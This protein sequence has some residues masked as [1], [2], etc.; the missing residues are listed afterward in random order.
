[1]NT[2]KPF[3]LAVEEYRLPMHYEKEKNHLM[4]SYLKT[5]IV[6]KTARQKQK[7]QMPQKQNTI[8]DVEPTLITFVPITC[9]LREMKRLVF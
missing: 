1:V 5:P 8:Y 2:G 9:S 7:N 6:Q 4:Q 3:V